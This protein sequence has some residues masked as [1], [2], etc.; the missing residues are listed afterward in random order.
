MKTLLVASLILCSTLAVAKDSSVFVPSDSRATYT[1]IEKRKAGSKRTIV[2]KR[3]GPSG[4]SF[5]IREVD[6]LT[7][8]F[9]YLGEGDTLAEAR[10]N[11]KSDEMAP[12]VHGSISY[13]IALEACER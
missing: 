8:A 1:F 7:Q 11:K 5:S 13:Y 9:R 12:L 10:R 6:C 3:V 4:T 2:T